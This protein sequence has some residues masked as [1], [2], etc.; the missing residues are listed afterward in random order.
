MEPALTEEVQYKR[1]PRFDHHTDYWQ[2]HNATSEAV[3]QAQQL[4][5]ELRQEV[6]ELKAEK[7][8][9]KSTT[10]RSKAASK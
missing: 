8:A 6:A 5:H 7:P 3:M 10:S 1:L 2:M 4:I 9:A